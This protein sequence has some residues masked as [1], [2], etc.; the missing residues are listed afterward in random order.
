V[1]RCGRCNDSEEV[2]SLTN[3]LE[4]VQQEAFLIY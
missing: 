1:H 3:F 4:D 2:G